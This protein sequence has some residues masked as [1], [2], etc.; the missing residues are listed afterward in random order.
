MASTVASRAGAPSRVVGR[1]RVTRTRTPSARHVLHPA[2][3]ARRA[4]SFRCRAEQ[5]KAEKEEEDEHEVEVV[6]EEAAEGEE[7]AEEET[8]IT[9]F[10]AQIETAREALAAHDM[11]VLEA[12]IDHAATEVG[13]LR[14]S[15]AEAEAKAAL[16]ESQATTLQN[17][18][19]RLQADFENFRRRSRDDAARAKD[20]AAGKV[21]EELLPLIDSFE[22]ARQQ[23]KVESE[24]EEKINNS[25]QG[26]YKQMVDIFRKL[27]V[28]AVPTTGED[29]DPEM[30][31]AIMREPRDDVPDGQV[32]EEF[33]KGFMVNGRL[34]RA[35]M[36]KVAYNDAAPAP[37]SDE[38]PSDDAE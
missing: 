32:I 24:A 31:E 26:I 21:V 6:E 14:E 13:D 12:F 18:Y 35:A 29:F 38:E 11:E 7:A 9:G 19:L 8:H 28:E 30:H 4:A 36:V 27:G 3:Q 20:D 16:A 25:Y 34:V 5:E 10:T 23:V 17:Q 2:P 37:S 33:R 22:L 1:F 15:S